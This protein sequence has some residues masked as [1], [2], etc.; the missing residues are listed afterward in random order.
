MGYPSSTTIYI[1]A[2][3]IDGG[4][5]MNA[6]REQYPN[7][8]SRSTHATEGELEPFREYQKGLATR[9]VK[10]TRLKAH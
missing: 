7:V 3:E 1:V 5:S 8:F 10:P 4:K 9:S 6:F 2:G